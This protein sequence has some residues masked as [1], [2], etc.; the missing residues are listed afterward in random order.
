MWPAPITR[1]A[2]FSNGNLWGS[3]M[4]ACIPSATLHGVDGRSVSVEV[5][6]SAGFPVS[7]FVGLPDAAVRESRDRV[8]GRA[9]VEP[10]AVA[11]SAGDGEPGAIGRAQDRRRTRP[12]HRHRAARGVRRPAGAV[13]RRNGLR[14]RIRTR[15]VCPP[16]PGIAS[17]VAA[18]DTEQVVVPAGASVEAALVVGERVRPASSVDAVRRRRCAVRRPGKR[19]R[20]RRRGRRRAVGARPP[21]RP[22]SARGAPSAGDR[23]R[24]WTPPPLGGRTGLGQDHVRVAA[25]RGSCP[26]SRG[27]SRSR[28]CASIPPRAS[29]CRAGVPVAA[30]LSGAAPQC[31]RGGD[32]G[33]WDVV[34]P[35]R[36]DLAGPRWGP[37]PRRAGG[38]SRPR[39]RCVAPAPRG[40]RHPGPAGPRGHRLPGPVPARRR[41]EPVP[42]WRGWV[43]RR[44]SVQRRHAPA[45]PPSPLGPLAR[46]LRPGHRARASRRRRPV[47][48]TSRRLLGGRGGSRATGG[49]LAQGR[50]V[51]CNAELVRRGRRPLHAFRRWRCSPR[52]EAAVGIAL[53]PRSCTGSAVSHRPSP[54]ST[55]SQAW[56]SGRWPRRWRCARPD[57]SSSSGAQQ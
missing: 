5:H 4:L 54:I 26:T 52:A 53:G 3:T 25:C 36:R 48:R 28:C 40:A 12:P 13:C 33:R 37:V 55:A 45:V 20:P 57:R 42:V 11:H 41:H 34:A 21:R 24:R 29:W 23:S 43:P 35:A 44:L 27:T 17:L 16:V 38:V 47:G 15:R 22:G 19:R 6:V 46:P 32:R 14:R 30:P 56:A 8:A 10:P 1:L 7:P 39:S 50:G 2:P 9:L 49:E 31:D 18:I 51:R